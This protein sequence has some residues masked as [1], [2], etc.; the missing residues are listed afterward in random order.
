[1]RLIYNAGIFFYIAIARIISPFNQKVRAWVNGRKNWFYSLKQKILPGEKYIWIHCASLGEFEQGRPV[2]EFIKKER[3]EYRILLSFF[4]PSGYEIR[5]DYP[6]A[7]IIC[8]LPYDTPRNAEKFISLVN[9]SVAILVKYEFWNN[10]ISGLSKKHIPLYLISGI[11]RKDQHFFKWYGGFFRK[12]LGKFTR[13]FVQDKES[14]DLLG[15]IG[16]TNVTIAGDTRI[17]RVAE[18][19]ARANEIPLIALFRGDQK[20]LL[21]GSSWRP[22]EEIIAK[23]INSHPG[24]MKWIFAPH[25]IDKD[26]IER[27]EKLFT[28]KSVRFSDFNANSADARVMIMD[29]MGLLSSAY[30]YAGIAAIGGG[31]G[32]GIHSILEPACWSIPVLFGPGYKK[33]REAVDLI[34]LGGAKSFNDY[35]GFEGI[36][37]EWISDETLYRKAAAQ[38]GEYIKKNMG[39]TSL[40]MKEIV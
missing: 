4:S 23:Y 26:N 14:S 7:D 1:M 20:L 12:M 6:L 17:D 36:I 10:F 38:A 39:A 21:A 27:L 29:N 33:F 40:I 37:D 8:Y 15:T 2:I 25:E 9:P 19:A 16:I 11:F 30:R 22:D 18:I 32:K 24:T 35:S 5:K 34:K 28:V 31:F 3:P 13:I